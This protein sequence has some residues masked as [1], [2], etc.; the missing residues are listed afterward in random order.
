MQGVLLVSASCW[1]PG[2]WRS[3]ALPALPGGQ[4]ASMHRGAP[5]VA[6]QQ[7]EA[8]LG[9]RVTEQSQRHLCRGTRFSVNSETIST[10]N[11]AYT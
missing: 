8:R 5:G 11:P 10:L 1:L 7:E 6:E 4:V 9:D 3:R 2:T